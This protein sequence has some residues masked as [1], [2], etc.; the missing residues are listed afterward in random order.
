MADA[1]VEEQEPAKEIYAIAK[2]DIG[3][4]DEDQDPS[5]ATREARLDHL[6]VNAR[7]A[8]MK[9]GY[10]EESIVTEKYLNMRYQGTDNAIMIKERKTTDGK[11]P[12]AKTFIEQYRRE[13]GFEL[14]GRD[15][16]I[17]DFRVRAFVAGP[18]LPPQHS[19]PLLGSPVQSGRTRAYFENGWE[20]G[21]LVVDVTRSAVTTHYNY[22]SP[23]LPVHSFSIH[24]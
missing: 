4:F 15:I 12:Y 24:L 2:V 5:A 13:F 9:Q 22:C 10:F 1:V 18:L 7:S 19:M 6:A 3:G 16:L 8:L 20:N 21:K 11:M 23:P 17:D 14:K